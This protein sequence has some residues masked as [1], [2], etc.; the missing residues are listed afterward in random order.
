LSGAALRVVALVNAA[1]GAL[2]GK[3]P[4]D[5]AKILA[6][7]FAARGVA[8]EVKFVSGDDIAAAAEGA[9]A[10]A[11]ARDIDAGAVGGGDGTVRTVAGVLAGSDVP[12]GLIPLGTLNHFARDLGVPADLDA[13]VAVIA[14]GVMQ[15][16]DVAEVNG[17]AFVN[18]SSIGVY[19]YMVLDRE[20]RRSLHGLGKWAAMALAAARTLRYLPLRRLKIRAGGEA[21]PHRT[22]CAFVGNNEYALA[23]P[24]LGRRERL[25][26]GT[27]CLYVARAEGRLALLWLAVRGAFGLVRE[28]RDLRQL[29]A[30]EAE[31]T[32]RT[33]RLP[34][35]LDG[36]VRVLRTPLRYRVRPRALR[37]FVPA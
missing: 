25:D 34:V 8:A 3:S 1:A 19:P 5:F 37:V 9:K 30:F 23:M 32:A 29:R 26:G 36:E 12:L 17:E 2:G 15:A 4:Q 14:G 27:L 33:S 13:A 28:A 35:A 22:P 31:I 10:R 16:V 6:A 7:A 20:R 11:A 24:G 21:E 18:N